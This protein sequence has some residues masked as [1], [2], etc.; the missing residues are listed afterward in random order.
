MLG[1]RQPLSVAE[2]TKLFRRRGGGRDPMVSQCWRWIPAP[3]YFLPGQA[4]AGMTCPA[5]EPLAINARVNIV[6]SRSPSKAL[7]HKLRGN[8]GV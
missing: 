3:A 8:G 4:R 5:G 6:D 1:R 7:E 2:L